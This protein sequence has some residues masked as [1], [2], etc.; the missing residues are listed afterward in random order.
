MSSAPSHRSFLDPFQQIHV[1][2]AI[3]CQD[4]HN[5]LPK[6]VYLTCLTT[7]NPDSYTSPCD[8]AETVQ[9]TAHRQPRQLNIHLMS[10]SPPCVCAITPAQVQ[11]TLL[12][13]TAFFSPPLVYG[14]LLSFCSC[15]PGGHSLSR[16]TS[17][18]QRFFIPVLSLGTKTLQSG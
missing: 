5:I 6:E 7:Y 11:R 2:F 9:P 17:R 18:I 1:Y 13:L 15:P 4:G 8:P 16:L 14:D 12:L 10:G 3:P